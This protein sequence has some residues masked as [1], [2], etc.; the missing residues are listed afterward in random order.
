MTNSNIVKQEIFR[1]QSYYELQAFIERAKSEGLTESDAI[2]AL[3]NAIEAVKEFRM[4]VE[5][6]IVSGRLF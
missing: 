5:D 3:E 6:G 2:E 1:L 4:R